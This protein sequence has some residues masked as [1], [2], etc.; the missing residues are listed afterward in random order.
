MAEAVFCRNKISSPYTR[1]CV[2]TLLHTVINEKH[3]VVY[4]QRSVSDTLKRTKLNVITFPHIRYVYM[5]GE[6]MP[7]T[8]AS[9]AAT[10]AE[11]KQ[12]TYIYKRAPG[13]VDAKIRRRIVYSYMS[14]TMQKFCL[15]EY[16]VYSSQSRCHI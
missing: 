5:L 11:G 3:N 16:C 8:E 13:G 6:R 7:A 10:I 12:G 4:E 2:L 15:S 1:V 9:A 14:F